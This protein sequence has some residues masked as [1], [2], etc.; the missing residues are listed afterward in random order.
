MDTEIHRQ[1]QSDTGQNKR[2]KNFVGFA[3]E[4]DLE[5]LFALLSWRRYSTLF[6]RCSNG[7]SELGVLI[8]KAWVLIKNDFVAFYGFITI[9]MCNSKRYSTAA[10]CPY[11]VEFCTWFILAR[12]CFSSQFWFDRHGINIQPTKIMVAVFKPQGLE[13]KHSRKCRVGS[14]RKVI[15]MDKTLAAFIVPCF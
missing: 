15:K 1:R 2:R 13:V 11:L 5:Y 10:K 8:E 14:N 12:M 3:C 7:R 6:G 4:Q 9:S